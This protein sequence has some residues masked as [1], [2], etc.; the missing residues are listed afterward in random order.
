[1]G[2]VIIQEKYTTLYP[3]TMIG[4]EAGI[5]RNADVSNPQKN[6]ERGI[7]CLKS[8]HGR[9][10]E[11]PD[12]YMIL[13]GYS[14]KV[15]REYYTHIGCL[16]TRLQESTRY[17]DSKNFDYTVPSSIESNIE[18]FNIYHKA[19]KQIKLSIKELEEKGISREDSAMLLPLC[20]ATKIIDKRN[21]RNLVDMSH[22]RMCSRAYW[23]FRELFDDIAKALSCYSG[24][25]K[26][27]VEH[28]FMPKC[29]LYGYCTESKSCGRR[30]KKE[31]GG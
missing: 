21:F 16:P 1:M 22:Q 25:W 3:I 18:L 12:V 17:V 27:L 20:M 26:Y 14:A 2:R 8:Q 6:Y 4:E 30:P 29:E 19:I 13:D 5:C 11:F 10:W 28:Y 9:T 15:I 24:E 23:E 7:N 31:K